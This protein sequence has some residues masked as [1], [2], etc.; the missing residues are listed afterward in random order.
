M[1]VLAK[2]LNRI[3]PS[4]TLAVTTKAAELKARGL[5]VIGLGIGEPDFGTPTHVKEAA[6][7][8]I[9]NDFTKYTAV[10][11]M[12]ELKQAICRKFKRENNIDYQ[13]NQI[14]VGTGAK[15]VIY[16]AMMA[17][18]DP[19]DEVIIPAPYWV[20]YPDMVELAEG[21]PVFV[22]CGPEENFK[23]TAKQLEKVITPKTKWLIL[24]S[25]SNPT[26]SAYSHNELKALTKVL[27]QHPHIYI[28]SDDIYEHLIYDG[29]K[30]CTPAEVEPQLYE[31]ILTVNGVSKAYAM[32]G[33]RIGYGAG[34]LELI[35]GISIIQSQST[36]NPC[37]ISQKA[38]IAALDGPQDCIKTNADIFV[39][40][41]D[42]V[43]SLLNQTNGIINCAKPDGAFYVFADCRKMFGK[44]TPKGK[45][46]RNSNE[47]AK[48]LLEEAL[49]AVV[50]GS[51]FGSEG[52]FRVSY[53]T[54]PEILTEACTRIQK[55]CSL[56]K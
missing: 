27:L 30:F 37:S 45:L 22:N 7:E 14:T 29:L 43:V 21:V 2:K 20:S 23:L 55:A 31:R 8:A 53:A 24:N 34:P 26:G 44:K 49:V 42:L 40:R 28:L 33:W 18:L 19:G 12:V 32:T 13:P 11:G 47:V 48:Y 41:R 39:P 3:K 46:L 9:N 54:S 38:A 16:N 36:T 10:D 51:A 35:Q 52:F 15:Q 50:P 4:P 25:P 5:D 1:S 6:I 17:S 56:L